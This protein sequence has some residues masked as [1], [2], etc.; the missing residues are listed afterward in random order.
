MYNLLKALKSVIERKVVNI[1]TI[2]SNVSAGDTTIP[3]KS[4]KRFEP[5]AEIIFYRDGEDDGEIHTIDSIV[6]YHTIT[7]AE[8]LLEDY[9]TTNT[10]VQNL[11]QGN[12]M[13]AIYIGDP[14][15]IPQF[16]AITIYGNSRN[17]E[18]LTLESLTEQYDVS[19]SVYI[20]TEFYDQGYEYVLN[21]TK[22][23]ENAL[24]FSMYPLSEPYFT[25]VLTEDVADTD[26]I[27]R[28]EDDDL[29]R[30]FLW[31]F[32]ENDKYTRHVSPL[33]YKGNGVI[34]LRA[35]VGAA[36]SAGDS[37][38]YPGRHFYDT[39]PQSTEYG[40]V[41]KNS[42]LWG[43]RISYFAKQ[44]RLINTKFFTPIDRD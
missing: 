23:I 33:E 25:T 7:L 18:W 22:E 5:C 43:S 27:I 16:P 4:A 12:W 19:I 24:Y 20:Q 13:H 38:I 37:V 21:L 15:V 40:S 31:F 26:T 32:L 39:R 1:Q 35:P 6:D 14:P 10:H 3:V 36:F 41:V 34:E 28:V 30:Q 8:P 44:E 11:V 2:R 29:N 42:L 9:S 17:S